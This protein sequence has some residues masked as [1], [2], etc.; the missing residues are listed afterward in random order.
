[1]T[2]STPQADAS[3]RGWANIP[4]HLWRPPFLILALIHGPHGAL[5]V[6]HA[7][8]ALVQAEVVPHGILGVRR[9]GGC[10]EAP[11]PL[12]QA[13][14]AKSLSH[15]VPPPLAQGQEGCPR[16]ES[17]P[18]AKAGLS[19]ALDPGTARVLRAHNPFYDLPPSPCHLLENPVYQLNAI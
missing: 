11:S 14:T 10:S 6:L 9:Q 7:H 15:H 3:A 12:R 13:H 2:R 4:R 8:E 5:N 18:G 1:M 19:P 16:E 17:Q